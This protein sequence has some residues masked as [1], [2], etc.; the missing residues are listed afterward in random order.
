[1]SHL[2]GPESPYII[3]VPDVEIDL[4]K[5]KLALVRFPDEL[6][7]AGWDYGAP[8]AHVSRLVDRWQNGFDWRK[9]EDAINKANPQ[10]TRDV[11]VEGFGSLN[12][13]YIHQKSECE[14]AVPLLFVH[15][16]RYRTCARQQAGPC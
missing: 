14:N 13:H 5:K 4:L 6:D 16:C 12:I 1:M 15:G 3:Q 7:S 2:A 10:F 8:I 11:L 9:H